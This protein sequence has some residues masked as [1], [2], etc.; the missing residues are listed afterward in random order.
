MNYYLYHCWLLM[1][2]Q[3]SRIYSMISDGLQM[4]HSYATDKSGHSR[5]D[6]LSIGEVLLYTS[7][8]QAN[9]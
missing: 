9:Y 5:V 2:L 3:E 6:T 4:T 1:F 8:Y 7:Q